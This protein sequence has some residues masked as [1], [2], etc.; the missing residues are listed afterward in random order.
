MSEGKNGTDI[1][2]I[3]GGAAGMMAAAAA[4]DSGCNVLLLERNEKLGRKLYI[5]GKGR[6]N[7]TN[8]CDTQELFS[9]IVRNPKFLYSAVYTFD[10]FRVMDFFENQG[11]PLTVERGNR[12]FPKS[13]HASDII[14][15]LN[16]S[17]ES[18]K[19][20]ICLNTRVTSV[21]ALKTGGFCIL[22]QDGR[23]FHA[24]KII[25]ATGGMSYPSTGSTGDGY[26]M[27]RQFGHGVTDLEPS[28][29]AM[30]TK[31]DV[32]RQL[33]GLSLKNVRARIY[34]SG[35]KKPVFDEFGE[36]LFTHFGVSGPLMLSAS[37]RIHDRLQ[38]APLCLSIDLKPA[39]DAGQLDRR[40]LRDFEENK[41]RSLKNSLNRLLPAKLIPAVIE[42]SGIGP[43]KKIHDITGQERAALL[44]SVKGFRATLT[45]FRGFDEAVVT[46][47]GV[48]VKEI[49][50]STMES[51]LVP[52][53][54]FAG[55]LIDADALTGG[56]NLQIAWSTGYLAGLSAAQSL[57][58]QPDG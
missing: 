20:G 39:L 27:A 41:N 24:R 36:M 56:F 3:G 26:D 12:V 45:G 46:R 2:V 37:A 51:R 54:Y 14:R 15:G 11:I 55:E 52:G 31:E 58:R 32:I 57:G 50:P 1:V 34:E 53:L 18:Q 7:V 19:A 13:G 8:A 29:V 42:Q 30:Y 16:R 10:N 22:A 21:Q 33:Q 44:D 17:L 25:L 4:A 43:E 35:G 9:N 6:C 38:K 48:T 49:N 5:T 47:G 23:Q 28:L 40:I